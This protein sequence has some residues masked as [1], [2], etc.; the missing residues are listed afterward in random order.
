MVWE[1]RR[2]SARGPRRGRALPAGRSYATGGALSLTLRT[3]RAGRGRLYAR[4]EAQHTDAPDDEVADGQAERG[5]REDDESEFFFQ[6]WLMATGTPAF[7]HCSTWSKPVRR[8]TYA[9][10]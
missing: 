4:E 10:R 6:A 5:R 1:A 8:A 2:G 7:T 3:G 9:C